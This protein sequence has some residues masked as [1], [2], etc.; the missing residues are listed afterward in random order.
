MALPIYLS[1]LHLDTWGVGRRLFDF[2]LIAAWCGSVHE[3]GEQEPA[4]AFRHL[5]QHH[6]SSTARMTA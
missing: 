5:P 1:Y 4:N 6:P 3:T 2:S